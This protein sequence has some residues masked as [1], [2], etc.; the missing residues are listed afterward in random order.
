MHHNSG[1]LHLKQVSWQITKLLPLGNFTFDKITQACYN[2]IYE[3][4]MSYLCLDPFHL[5]HQS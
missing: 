2:A 1:Q 4:V 3:T 5:L